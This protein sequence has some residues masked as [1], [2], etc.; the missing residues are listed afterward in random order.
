MQLTE[1]EIQS[2]VREVLKRLGDV[3]VN[4]AP[5]P[6]SSVPAD[7]V[8]CSSVD[9]AVHRAKK[10]QAIFQ[11]LGLEQ[12]R[13]IIDAMRKAGVENATVLAKMANE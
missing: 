10:A 9:Q 3:S 1:N 6:V 13:N 7:G 5:E 4:P 12:R 11:E 2:L 8:V